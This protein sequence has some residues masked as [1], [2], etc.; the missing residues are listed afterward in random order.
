M[1]ILDGSAGFSAPLTEQE[2]KE[3]LSE[4]KL[5]IHIATLDEKW[6]AQYTSNMVLF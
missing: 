6:T 1:R 5:N 4:S 2:A 3:F